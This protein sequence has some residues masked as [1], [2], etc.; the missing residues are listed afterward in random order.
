MHTQTM[1]TVCFK[2]EGVALE[3]CTLKACTSNHAHS[4]HTAFSNQRAYHLSHAHSIYITRVRAICTPLL[5]SMCTGHTLLCSMCTG[6]TLLCSMCT[7][8]T[9][10]CSMCTGHTLRQDV[11]HSCSA[12]AQAPH[13][14]HVCRASR[15]FRQPRCAREP[16]V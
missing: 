5:C 9:L 13:R 14:A 8:H 4:N 6:H 12:R 10:L 7:G 11:V 1:H 2:P 3:S 16:M 15:G